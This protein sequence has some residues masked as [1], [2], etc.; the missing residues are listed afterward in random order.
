MQN[1]ILYLFTA[2]FPYANRETFIE[3][4]INYLC[5]EFKEVV[6]IP[7]G[8]YGTAMRIVPGN[9]KVWLP[10][11]KGNKVWQYMHFFNIKSFELFIVDFFKHKVFLNKIRFKTF[12]I[13]LSITNCYLGNTK[14]RKLLRTLK[15]QDILYS[16]WG[17]GG[18]YLAPFLKKGATFISRFHGEWDLWEESSGN[19]AP[20]RFEVT[21]NLDFAVFIA[22]KGQR[23][24]EQKYNT[25]TILSRLGTTNKGFFANKSTDGVI[26][27][28]SCSSVYPLKR[29]E[30]IYNAIQEFSSEM[31]EWTHIGGGDDFDNLE[32]RVKSTRP[33]V[34]VR[35]LGQISNK[36]VMDYYK[37]NFVDMFINVSM[38]E[39]IPVS[40][41]E[42]LSYD[43]PAIATD[44][45]GNSEV[46]TRESGYL[47]PANPSLMEIINAIIY[48]KKH[49]Y[50]AHDFWNRYY[51]ADYN[52]SNFAKFLVMLK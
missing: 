39:G 12:L 47:L 25:N 49:Q 35:L 31:I 2:T 7:L 5:K 45:G 38:N 13:A 30:M 40:I 36:E 6:I 17:K 10:I 44:V 46:V 3:T 9:C 1:R 11:L 43:I 34:K 52:Y 22:E 16:Y 50:K 27:I 26:R 18:C 33:N 15:R 48:V 24:F 4:E 8:G 41:M 37:N 20:L 14:L 23:Y 19:Y 51:N 42:A 32:K 21:K 28:V 29:V